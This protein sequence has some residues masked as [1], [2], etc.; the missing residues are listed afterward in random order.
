MLKIP[1]LFLFAFIAI[2]G[3]AQGTPTYLALTAKADSLLEKKK[4]QDAAHTYLSAFSSNN[5]MAQVK[6]RYFLA[7][8]Y[9]ELGKA[10]SAFI[11]LERIVS[12]GNYYNYPQIT[13]E[14]HFKKLYADSRWQPLLARIEARMKEE[15]EKLNKDI[16]QQGN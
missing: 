11:Q 15:Q 4:Y 1:T 12:K 9:A 6:H 13:E 10:D 5:G 14:T 16:P 2:K 7:C 8:A 3:A